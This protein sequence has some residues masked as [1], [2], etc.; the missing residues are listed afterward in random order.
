M[1]RKIFLSDLPN[2]VTALA[3]AVV[4]WILLSQN[5]TTQEKLD[6]MPC[7]AIL[8]VLPPRGVGILKVTAADEK[9]GELQGP[10]GI[11]IQVTLRGPRRVIQNLASRGLECRHPLA[12][13]L[14]ISADEPTIIT[15]ALRPWDFDLPRGVD[16]MHIDPQKI[17][18]QVAQEF[19]RSLRIDDDPK[20]SLRGPPP[21]GFQVDRVT[22]EPTFVHVRGLRHVLEFLHTIPIIPVDIR[23]RT[24]SFTQQVW[25]QREIR[26]T[27]VTT[28]ERIQ[29]TVAIRPVDVEQTLSALP[30]QLVF[31]PGFSQGRDRVRVAE[32]QAV[33]AHLRGPAG[34]V[35]SLA[36]FGRIRILAEV[37]ETLKSKGRTD[38]SLVPF[39][40]DP[41][42]A[43][44]VKIRLDPPRAALEAGE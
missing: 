26:G 23:D 30:V 24:Q 29:M 28:D 32:P 42:A 2:K 41:E 6:T 22:F 10:T 1:I 12:I 38:V 21:A 9:E 15:D 37:P 17:K 3:L 18:V 20:R 34:A 14:P 19:V 13:S 5:V 16:V 11:P 31:P 39:V 35:E 40:G 44:S 8:I 7:R 33:V 27:P 25:I 4:V 36:K 43:A